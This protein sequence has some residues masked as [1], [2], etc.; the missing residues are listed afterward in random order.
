MREVPF[1][2]GETISRTMWKWPREYLDQ[3]RDMADTVGIIGES[4]TLKQAGNGRWMGVC[5]FHPD[6]NPSFSVSQQYGYRCFGCDAK[7][8]I[9]KFLMAYR[10]MTFGE[11]VRYIQEVTGLVAPSLD[12]IKLR[13][14]DIQ[15]TP[16]IWAEDTMEHF[17]W[18]LATMC[19]ARLLTHGHI[20]IVY[21]R[22]MLIFREADDALERGDVGRIKDIISKLPKLVN[23]ER[24]SNE[25]GREAGS[26]AEPT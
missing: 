9:F 8:D 12:E 26:T 10:G 1:E 4:V 24:I 19:N 25:P 14:W 13:Y 7:G 3:L 23:L 18:R 20:P 22:I 11:A 5:P 21:E 15:P 2:D 17:L 6:H 16:E